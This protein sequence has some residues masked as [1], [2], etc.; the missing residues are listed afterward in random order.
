MIV[1]VGCEKSQIVTEA[2]RA[3]GV[4]AHSCD[5]QPCSGGHPEW[6]FQEDILEL[7]KRKKFDLGIFHPPCTDIAVSGNRSFSQKIADG[8][9]QRA[10]DFFL[11]LTNAPIE[12]I[13]IENPVCI[14]SSKYRKPDQI[15]HPYFFGDNVPK[16]TCLWLKN[17]PPLKYSLSDN[18]FESKTSVEPEY[19]E[20]NSKKTK[21]GKSRYS[22]FGKLGKGKGEERSVFFPGT[23][24]AMAEQ[25]TEYI[26]N[27]RK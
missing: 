4:E 3:I 26:L 9:Q 11:A 6:H 19:F 7:L 1:I 2:F 17:L 24:R 22:R 10:I 21:S 23:A 14:M 16:K 12:N 13:A 20:Y 15:I 18:L 27:K 8:R 25:W 5:I